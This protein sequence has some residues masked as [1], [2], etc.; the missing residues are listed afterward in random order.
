MHGAKK[1]KFKHSTHK[2]MLFE[3]DVYF[4]PQSRQDSVPSIPGRLGCTF[5]ISVT[6]CVL[7]PRSHWATGIE[8]ALPVQVKCMLQFPLA[9]VHDI[10]ERF[11]TLLYSYI[12][13]E[14][15]MMM[16]LYVGLILI[17]RM[18]AMSLATK[19]TQALQCFSP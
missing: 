2:Y 12:L 14:R 7:C 1:I 18:P 5:D 15:H 8:L 13:V 4:H 3:R 16:V 9:R 17:V 11:Y 19:L 6:T 10:E